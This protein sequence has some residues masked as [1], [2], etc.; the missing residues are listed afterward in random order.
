MTPPPVHP[1]LLSILSIPE[2]P[3]PHFHFS[4]DEDWESIIKEATREGLI[5]LLYKWLKSSRSE[6]RVPPRIFDQIRKVYLG[7]FARN[8]LL[9]SELRS[10]LLA[11]Q[12][13]CLCGA[14]LRGPA[15]AEHLY[16]N[17]GTRQFGDLDLLVHKRDVP[18]VSAILRGLGYAEIDRRPGFAREFSYTLEYFKDRHGWIIVEPHW[19]IAYPP[20]ADRFDMESVWKRCIRGRVAGVEA[21]RLEREE[22][23]LHLCLHLAH[24]NGT[25][26]LLWFYELD[27]FIALEQDTLDW[28]Q[29]LLLSRQE[30]IA[31]HVSE[32]LAEVKTLF[33][34]PVPDHVFHSLGPFSSRPTRGGLI[35]LLSGESK[36]DGKESFA[37]FFYLKGFRTKIRYGLS[38]LFPSFEFMKVHYGL[39]SRR[40]VVSFY[41]RRFCHLSWEGVKGI[42]KLIY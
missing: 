6:S 11:F 18:Q 28:L 27:R 41:L 5:P 31:S 35:H 9:S 13:K 4:D 20:Y 1:F 21:W 30:G 29:F 22:L 25:A 24:R 2:P 26:P 14:P 42:S 3:T 10:I 39:S 36:V 8:L 38:L 23:L 37:L 33:K 32:T 7:I 40:E 17:I 16:G 34:T 19:S 15:L 12:S